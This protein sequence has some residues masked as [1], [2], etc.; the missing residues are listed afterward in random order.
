[1]DSNDKDSTLNDIEL[2]DSIYISP[3][4]EVRTVIEKVELPMDLGNG[5]TMMAIELLEGERNVKYTVAID[6]NIIDMELLKQYTK[7]NMLMV[8]KTGDIQSSELQFWLYC[9][10]NDITLK[11]IYQSKVNPKIMFSVDLSVED[12]SNAFQSRNDFKTK[13]KSQ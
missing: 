3:F 4:D 9:M 8:I 6:E 5:M 13:A 2:V 10:N 7:S 12:L 1:M 11:Y